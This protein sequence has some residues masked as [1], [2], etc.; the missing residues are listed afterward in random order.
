[1]NYLLKLV[2]E[3]HWAVRAVFKVSRYNSTAHHYVTVLES[4]HLICDCMMAI[5]LGI[6]C[7]H[8][9]AL[10]VMTDLIFHLSMYNRR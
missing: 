9:W 1:M 10:F 6:L 2:H 7:R 5:N 4:G 8:I 3:R